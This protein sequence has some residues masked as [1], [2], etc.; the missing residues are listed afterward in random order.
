MRCRKHIKNG[1]GNSPGVSGKL[2]QPKN[3]GDTIESRK[4]ASRAPPSRAALGGL[5]VPSGSFSAVD[6]ATT[7][8]A[9]AHDN[10]AG[11]RAH[12]IPHVPPVEA[13]LP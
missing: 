10:Q 2:R 9:V 1:T 5:V 12:C 6:C 13:K 11:A 8:A 4:S 7:P 3:R